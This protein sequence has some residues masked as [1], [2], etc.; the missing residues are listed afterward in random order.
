M[1]ALFKNPNIGKA[2][3]LSLEEEEGEPLTWGM[4]DYFEDTEAETKVDAFF[5][6]MAEEDFSLFYEGQ[7]LIVLMDTQNLLYANVVVNKVE[8]TPPQ[9]HIPCSFVSWTKL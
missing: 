8:R 6:T 3:Y 5:L 2:I 7:A 4:A 1:K 9:V